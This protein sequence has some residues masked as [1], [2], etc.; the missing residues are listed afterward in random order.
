MPT[1]LSG[2]PLH[3]TRAKLLR[4]RIESTINQDFNSSP[5]RSNLYALIVLLSPSPPPLSLYL[6][7]SSFHD[8]ETLRIRYR[9]M[10]SNTAGLSSRSISPGENRECSCNVPV[11]VEEIRG[12]R[13][14]QKIRV[15]TRK[16]RVFRVREK[17]WEHRG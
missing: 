9:S 1:L 12:D 6:L 17:V 14:L 15:Y 3:G 11:P 2:H 13:D 10:P 5:A 8:A 7:L 4:G 16:T